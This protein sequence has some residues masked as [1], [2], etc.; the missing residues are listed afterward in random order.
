ME[1]RNGYSIGQSDERPWGRWTVVDAGPGFCIKRITVTPGGVLS[2]Q[3]HVH[4]A[5]DWIVVAGQGRATIEGEV[6]DLGRG[7]RAHIAPLATHR[8][9]NPG[10]SDLVFIEVQQGDI[11]SES[12]IERLGDSYGRKC[13]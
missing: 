4:R 1:I 3:R 5:E 2:L 12:D 7:S 9:A 10:V 13:V 8:I 6:I 11:L